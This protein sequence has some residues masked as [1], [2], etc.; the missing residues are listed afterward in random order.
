MGMNFEDF[1]DACCGAVL[2]NLEQNS[3]W[4]VENDL[5]DAFGSLV[6]DYIDLNDLILGLEVVGLHL[7]VKRAL[8]NKIAVIHFKLQRDDLI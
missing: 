7:V 1:F 5:A 4:T 3:I 8:C 6:L 2:S